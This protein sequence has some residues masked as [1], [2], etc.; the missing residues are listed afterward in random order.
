VELAVYALDGRVVA[1]IDA[2]RQDA[3]PREVEW[4]G[5]DESGALLPPGVYLLSIAPK[6]EFAA[7]ARIGP[8]GI[9]Y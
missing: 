4:D 1:R 5:R 2:G 8:L 3:G 9:A 6:A 7:P